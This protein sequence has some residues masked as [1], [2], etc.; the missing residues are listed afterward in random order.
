[1][2]INFPLLIL[3]FCIVCYTSYNDNPVIS[4]RSNYNAAQGELIVIFNFT[5]IFV[6]QS[7]NDNCN[8]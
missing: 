2:G 7:S 1:M 3:I 6:F 8:Y 5:L 4:F